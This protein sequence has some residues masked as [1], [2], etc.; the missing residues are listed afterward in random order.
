[1]DPILEM[2]GVIR[3]A[4]ALLCDAGGRMLLVRKR[5]TSAFMQPGGKI[6]PHEEPLAALLRELREELGLAVH[7]TEPVHLGRFRAPAAHEPGRAVDCEL[8]RVDIVGDVMP[9]AEIAEIA[10]VGPSPS[11]IELAP[12]TE[13]HVLP[14]YA[15]GRKACKDDR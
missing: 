7:P 13:F 10:W 3:I 12:L 6:E 4:A 9:A 11:G 14:L 5:G 1:M 2:P 8:Y 15:A